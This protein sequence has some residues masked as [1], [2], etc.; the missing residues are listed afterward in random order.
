[1]LRER[2]MGSFPDSASVLRTRTLGRRRRFLLVMSV[3]TCALLCTAVISATVGQFSVSMGEV[4]ASFGRFLIGASDPL[5]SRV[6]AALWAIRFPRTGFALIA[7]ACLGL[8]GALM[9]GVFANPLAEPSVIGV[10]A[11]A[12]VGAGLV[13]VAGFAA[14]MPF[15][16]PAAAFGGAI[17]ATGVVWLLSRSN[18]RAS[19]FALVLTGIAVNAVAGAMT[20]FLIFLADSTS[21][22]QIIF[23]QLGTLAN[24]TWSAVTLGGVILVASLI[25][26]WLMHQ[27]LDVLSLGDTSA[28]AT[29]VN[30]ETLRI[31]AIVIAC[32]L[33]GAA[34]SFA[35]MIGF[36][37]LIVP[38]AARLLVGPAHRYVLP[39]SALGGALLLCASDIAARTLIP[40]ADIPIGIFTAVLGGPLFLVLLRR[41]LQGKVGRL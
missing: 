15:M 13:M 28:T 4:V 35:G 3:L 12:S 9:Q 26:C 2:R 7:G 8:A 5:S 34:I 27:K 16:L 23:W 6:D 10:N 33:T 20:S 32:V 17:M 31:V 19:V 21:R 25:A 14:T 36:V 41:T 18:G 29:G 39:L 37:G 24:S 30:V 40:F 22:E 11:G 38:H 1:M